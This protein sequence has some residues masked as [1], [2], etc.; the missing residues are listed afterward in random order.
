MCEQ[1]IYTVG[2]KVGGGIDGY[3]RGGG[4]VLNGWIV[5]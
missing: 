5:V 3:R 1:R 4:A 2:G